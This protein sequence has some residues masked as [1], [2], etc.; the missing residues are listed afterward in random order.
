MG[1]IQEGYT[2]RAYYEGD[3]QYDYRRELEM[4]EMSRMLGIPDVKI[5][6][7]KM[8]PDAVLPTRANE[9]DSGWDLYA[10]EDTWLHHDKGSVIVATGLQ[11][12]NLSPGY[13]LQVRGRS[14]NS[15]KLSICVVN[16]PGTID[17]GYRGEI[18][19]I[20]KALYQSVCIVKGKAI[21]QLVPTAI[22]TS[23]VAWIEEV[24]AS[25]RGAKGFGSSGV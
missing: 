19:V 15:A 4:S 23:T 9:T 1:K 10:V 6:F 13:E 20:M 25:A 7:K 8:H 17:N 24:S 14:G 22:P 18:G 2:E 21:A 12:A 3:K 11:L 16:G 5:A